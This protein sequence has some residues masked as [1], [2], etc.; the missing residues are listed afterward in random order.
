MTGTT[1]R[2]EHL[3][4]ENQRRVEAHEERLAP[5]EMRGKIDHPVAKEQHDTPAERGRISET[6]AGRGTRH[7]GH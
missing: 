7:E 2:P 4:G 3:E 1:N 6:G 5:P